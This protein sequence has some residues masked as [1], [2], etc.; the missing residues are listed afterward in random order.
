MKTYVFT[1]YDGSQTVIH[2]EMFKDDNGLFVYCSHEITELRRLAND[3]EFRMEVFESYPSNEK[4]ALK[5]MA[6]GKK[7]DPI[8]VEY[9]YEQC[10]GGPEEGGWFYNAYTNPREV[11]KHVDNSHVRYSYQ[12]EV[13]S[14]DEIVIGENETTERPHYC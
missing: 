10:Y 13:E 4:E 12:R 3:P 8:I 14:F 1:Y 9:D 5:S 6:G 2:A 11:D 7:D